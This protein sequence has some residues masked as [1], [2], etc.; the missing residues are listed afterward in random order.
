[1]HGIQ[2]R[3]WESAS[4][5][6][7]F[8]CCNKA[9]NY[10][11]L[12]FIEIV[13][14]TSMTLIFREKEKRLWISYHVFLCEWLCPIQFVI[15]LNCSLSH[16]RSPFQAT[17]LLVLTTKQFFHSKCGWTFFFFFV[18]IDTF[19]SCIAKCIFMWKSYMHCA[20]SCECKNI[21]VRI[22]CSCSSFKV[23]EPIFLLCFVVC[24]SVLFSLKNMQ[25]RFY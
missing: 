2:K 13:Q 5:K 15:Y 19:Y 18:T 9:I 10:I 7:L 23:Y 4:L 25:H 17:H 20:A 8:T 6:N 11:F 24:C 14:V 21:I 22:Y 16:V 1:M 12:Y 3:T